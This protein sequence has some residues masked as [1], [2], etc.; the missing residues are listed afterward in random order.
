MSSSFE[1]NHWDAKSLSRDN[2]TCR[3]EAIV[4]HCT[5]CLYHLYSTVLDA[6]IICS[7][8]YL[9]SVSFV[10]HCTWCPYHLFNTVFDVRIICT[11]LYLMPV[12]FVQHC[13][14]CLYYLFNTVLDVCIICTALYLMSVSF[15]Q[16]CTWCPYHLF[17]YCT[18]ES[19]RMEDRWV[20]VQSE[21]ANVGKEKG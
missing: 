7:T 9:M 14:W 2:K 4:Q 18:C 12:S 11:A 15:V 17:Q 6:C 16:H 3:S 5:W 10:Q 20:V 8:L 19:C 13:T 1:S 21:G